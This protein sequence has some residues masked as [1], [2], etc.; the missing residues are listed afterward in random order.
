MAEIERTL[1]EDRITTNTKVMHCPS[2]TSCLAWLS[3]LFP[4]QANFFTPENGASSGCAHM[5]SSQISHFTLPKIWSQVRT[6]FLLGSFE[7]YPMLII[8]RHLK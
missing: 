6:T 4:L 1:S 8:L 3:V 2:P 7:A 5:P